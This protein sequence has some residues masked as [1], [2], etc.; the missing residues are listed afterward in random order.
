MAA[1]GRFSRLG[2]FG[3]L[4]IFIFVVS[5][6]GAAVPTGSLTVDSS[7]EGAS[8]FIDGALSGTTP[9]TSKSVAAGDHALV[10][11][12]QGYDDLA[13]T[14]TVQAGGHV[15]TSYSLVP[16]VTE[17]N[18]VTA[19]PSQTGVLLIE[20]D[21]AGASVYLDGDLVG[22]TPYT[23][24]SVTVGDHAV[25][26][27]K[28]GY[29]DI[30]STVTITPGGTTEGQYTLSCNVLT[31]D[32]NPSG[33]SVFIDGEL[34][35][36]TPSS[37]RAIPSG[38]YTVTLKKEGYADYSRTVTVR[39]GS[40]VS[41]SATLK[42]SGTA[43]ATGT[44]EPARTTLPQACSR[45]ITGSGDLMTSA[46]GTVNCTITVRTDDRLAVLTI[47]GGTVSTDPKGN[48]IRII[49]VHALTSLEG[50]PAVGTGSIWTGRAYTY[51]P[52][53]ASFRPGVSFSFTLSRDD[54][55][56]YD[57][58][59]L[60]LRETTTHGQ[61]WEDLPTTFDP[62]AKTLSTS[63]GHFGT[64]GIFTKEVKPVATDTTIAGTPPATEPA[65]PPSPSPA[66]PRFPE[67]IV[68]LAGV[69]T[70]IAVSVIGTMAG[71]RGFL[72][73]LWDRIVDLI[74]NFFGDEISG[75]VNESEIQRRAIRPAENLTS[76]I[77]GFSSREILALCAGA[78]VFG[79]AFMIQDRL[80]VDLV[81]IG[82]FVGAGGVATLLPDLANKFFA[83]RSGCVTEYRIWGLG[84][85]TMLATAWLFQN[86]FSKPSRALIM[87][88]KN[89]SAGESAVIKLAGPLTNII[90]AAAF[91][92]LIPLGG[93][94][95]VAGSA[96]FSINLLNGVFSLLPIKPNE[97]VE[98][99]AWNKGVWAAVF[100]PVTALYL[101]VFILM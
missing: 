65:N 81:T 16:A 58:Q 57:P 23:A 90:V 41:F 96:G 47:D 95:A 52:E 6:A 40:E 62:A 17:T 80:G 8:V 89:P 3:I 69:A 99:F 59:N 5:A 56:N 24:K 82:I 31:V 13:V 38:T 53:K 61:N 39:P 101:Y 92:G 93:L 97:G 51:L 79:A 100:F 29:A 76:V 1:T 27:S 73:Q 48:P 88:E 25:R 2:L 37:I 30:G 83:H 43:T 20:S 68:P 84:I 15:T 11:K 54:L 35:G 86:T 18:V 98:I 26:L 19:T 12:L 77:L 74:Q 60:T 7:P 71:V 33:A 22:T 91:L 9:F 72:A 21:P 46:D 75:L 44:E 10:L 36:T 55:E 66:T 50:L 42:A 45:E 70:G 85:F 34:S 94:F 32:S 78:A 4:L 14:I 28:T 67:K 49:Q 87:G 63:A 64:I